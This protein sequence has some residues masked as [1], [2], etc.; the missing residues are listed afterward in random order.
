[1]SSRFKKAHKTHALAQPAGEPYPHLAAEQSGRRSSA[2]EQ[3]LSLLAEFRSRVP[4]VTER[5][6]LLGVSP[7]L[8]AA[9][10]R[11]AALPVLRARRK[12]L[13]DALDVPSARGRAQS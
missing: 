6:A 12:A 8:V 3:L 4:D 5:A 1:M 9:W 2:D 7:E 10:D 11:G 13:A